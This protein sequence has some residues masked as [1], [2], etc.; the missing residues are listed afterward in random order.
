MM[1]NLHKLLDKTEHH[2]DLALTLNEGALALFSSLEDEIGRDSRFYVFRTLM[3]DQIKHLYKAAN[4]ID[5]Y[6]ME[7]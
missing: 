7:Q 5:R 1:A 2:L 3:R 6:R 4:A